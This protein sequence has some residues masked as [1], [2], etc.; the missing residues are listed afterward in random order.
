MVLQPIETFV[1]QRAVRLQP[2]VEF[3]QRLYPNSIE[4]PLRVGPHFDESG[5]LH[6]AQMLRDR[7]LREVE[8]I[9]EFAD[10]LLAVAQD[11]EDSPA[12]RLGQDLDGRSCGHVSEYT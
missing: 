4:A 12:V 3:L 7:R 2:R 5:L 6:H 1:P 11:V 8:P 9:D 10:W